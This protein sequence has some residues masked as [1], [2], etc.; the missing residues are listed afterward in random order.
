MSYQSALNWFNQQPTKHKSLFFIALM[1]VSSLLSYAIFYSPAV[2]Q[3]EKSRY[4]LEQSRA[5]HK[6]TRT[7]A[8]RSTPEEK[9]EHRA[10]V[11]AIAALDKE[12]NLRGVGVIDQENFIKLIR[13]FATR[14]N[15]VKLVRLQAEPPRKEKQVSETVDAFGFKK[16]TLYLTFDATFSGFVPFLTVLS[17]SE[18]PFVM[19]KMSIDN[20]EY[21]V[22]KIDMVVSYLLKEGGV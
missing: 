19:E 9:A 1:S 22:L 20:S 6:K 3:L 13:Q 5:E 10:L 18:F 16:D 15:D 21:P 17:A 11:D 7:P 8:D 2:T 14:H 12:L 4:L